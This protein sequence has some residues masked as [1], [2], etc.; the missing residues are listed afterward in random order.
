M[1]PG[2]TDIRAAGSHTYFVGVRY[3]RGESGASN[4]VVISTSGISAVV[5]DMEDDADIF[6]LTGIRVGHGV[7]DFD[8]LPAGIYLMGGR[9]ITVMR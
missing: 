7:A 6:T 4:E 9:K 2:Y 8:R 3:N 5:A 1:T